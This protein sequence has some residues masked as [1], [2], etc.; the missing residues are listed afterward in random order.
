MKKS[1]SR[2]DNFGSN[3]MGIRQLDHTDLA[4]HI[5]SLS[6]QIWPFARLLI[7]LLIRWT[8]ICDDGHL[9]VGSLVTSPPSPPPSYSLPGSTPNSL[10]PSNIPPKLSASEFTKV[11]IFGLLPTV[12]EKCNDPAAETNSA[13]WVTPPQRPPPGVW[14]GT[15]CGPTSSSSRV[16]SRYW[17]GVAFLLFCSPK[18]LG[19]GSSACILCF[20]WICFT[21]WTNTFCN[22]KDV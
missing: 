18:N 13:L 11:A 2:L 21:I 5:G 10:P 20:G 4:H 1:H 17:G 22:L 6:N 9:W 3:M 19:R 8:V 7:S 12:G 16:K 15:G 14:F